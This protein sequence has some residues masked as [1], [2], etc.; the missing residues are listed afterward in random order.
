MNVGMP[1]RSRN[2]RLPAAPDAPTAIAASSLDSPLVISRQNSRSTSRR[3]EGAPGDFIGDLPVNSFIQPAGLHINTSTIKVLRGP[4]ESALHA[5]VGVD[6]RSRG[7]LTGLN[8]HA[9]R[10][11]DQRGRR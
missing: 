1:P 9:Q 10:V 8:R 4:V 3:S 11:G 6:D 2:H 7:R 5:A